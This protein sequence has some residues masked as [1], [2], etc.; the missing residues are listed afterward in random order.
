[1]S[2]HRTRP[3][4]WPLVLVRLPFLVGSR[5]VVVTTDAANVM[6][7]RR[8]MCVPT[9]PGSVDEIMWSRAVSDSL[10][11]C[12]LFL[13]RSFVCSFVLLLAPLMCTTFRHLTMLRSDT[14]CWN[15]VWTGRSDDNSHTTSRNAG[16]PGELHGRHTHQHLCR[17]RFQRLE[18]T[19]HGS[20]AV[21]THTF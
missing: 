5:K 4:F 16:I 19:T 2:H 15:S 17:K 13:F 6:S 10:D 11:I 1:M 14:R 18:R 9:N 12:R 20:T 7:P 21:E 8:G 3:N